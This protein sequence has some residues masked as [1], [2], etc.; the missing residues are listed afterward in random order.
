MNTIP[1]PEI[2]YIQ[3]ELTDLSITP[4]IV[5][6]KLVK[7]KENMACGPDLTHPKILI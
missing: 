1:N 6:Q 2:C 4:E 7:F 3:S 5:K